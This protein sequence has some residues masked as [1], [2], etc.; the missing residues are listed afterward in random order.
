VIEPNSILAG[1]PFGAAFFFAGAF[2]LG[3]AVDAAPANDGRISAETVP[4][5]NRSARQNAKLR[6]IFDPSVPGRNLA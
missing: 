1:G 2:G 3:L 4:H 6:M 5:A